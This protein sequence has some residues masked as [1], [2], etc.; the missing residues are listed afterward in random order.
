[1]SDLARKVGFIPKEE[2]RQIQEEDVEIRDRLNAVKRKDEAQAEALHIAAD[3][4][5]STGRLRDE[6]ISRGG[7]AIVVN[8]LRKLTTP[9]G[10]AKPPFYTPTPEELA[11]AVKRME[12]S[13]PPGQSQQ[14]SGS[15]A[16]RSIPGYRPIVPEPPHEMERK[17]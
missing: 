2:A 8:A 10:P 6:V 3:K 4:L 7:A 11:R 16:P 14:S 5:K 15:P 17:E 9:T 12:S 13:R 1:M